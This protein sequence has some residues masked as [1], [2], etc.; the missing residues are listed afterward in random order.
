[1]T[2]KVLAAVLFVLL[3]PAP[4]RAV[5]LREKLESMLTVPVRCTDLRLPLSGYFLF[6]GPPVLLDEGRVCQP[7]R[8]ALRYPVRKI[9]PHWTRTWRVSFA[10]FTV[11]HERAHVRQW[12]YW[13][14]AGGNPYLAYLYGSE[15]RADCF[16][17]RRSVY[18]IRPF[19]TNWAVARRMARIALKH[20]GY[21]PPAPR[22]CYP[23]FAL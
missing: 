14:A 11:A 19:T 6:S 12:R 17:Y 21:S 10:A 23:A 15:S 3:L 18:F 20:F 1:M 7:L 5:T 22:S 2:W 4:A 8:R 13:L 16:A 9:Y